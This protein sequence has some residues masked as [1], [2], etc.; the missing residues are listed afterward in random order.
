MVAEPFLCFPNLLSA[1][2]CSSDGCAS[3]RRI[4]GIN[5]AFLLQP[6]L[7]FRVDEIDLF[8]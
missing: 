6:Q 7:P 8:L 1:L 4:W 2:S 3:Q 5:C